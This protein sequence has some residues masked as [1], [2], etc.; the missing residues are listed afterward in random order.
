MQARTGDRIVVESAHVGQPRR[1]GEV[2]EVVPGDGE[3][4]HYRVRWDD[5][6]ESI[7]FPSSDC[8]VVGEGSSN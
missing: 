2:L 5:G 8:R 1:E 7:Y 6:H 4:E 3:R